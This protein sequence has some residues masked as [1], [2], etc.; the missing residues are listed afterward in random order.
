MPS[1]RIPKSLDDVGIDWVE[2]ALLGDKAGEGSLPGFRL[3]PLESSNSTTARLIFE[4][5]PQTGGLPRSMVLKLCPDGH[6]FLGASEPHYYQRDYLGLKDSPLV[7]CYQAVG[8][9]VATAQSGG[10]G[11]ALF[12]EDLS[13]DYTSNKGITPTAGHAEHLGTALGR[14]HAHRWGA[15]ADPDGP[16]DLEADFQRFMAHVSTGLDPVLDTLGD[17]L[18]PS[19]RARLVKVF[20]DDGPRM[21]DRAMEGEGLA[22]VHGDPNPTNVL[23][24]RAGT[25][26]GQPL[27][28]IDRQPF[29][30][31]LRLWLGASDLVYAAVPFWGEDNRRAHQK[32]VMQSYHGALLEG[33][34][35]DYSLE[36]LRDDWCICACM[37]AFTAVEWGADPESCIE[38]KW[39]WERQVNRALT[40]FEDCDA[41]L[42]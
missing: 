42:D 25:R 24:P 36:D 6:G 15:E 8:P 4:D 33:G 13:A 5:H 7:T 10:M 35:R 29:E 3:E 18:A 34:V 39:L 1:G 26:P 21:L 17:A 30:W 31:A 38:M 28:L 32:T 41:G 14:L 11:Y 40:L 20:D 19:G 27:Y 2:R 12:L 16:H 9:A 22:L 23:V 37:A